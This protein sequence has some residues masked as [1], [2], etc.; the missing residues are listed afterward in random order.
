[1]NE[2]IFGLIL[3]ACWASSMPARGAI[4]ICG[5]SHLLLSAIDGLAPELFYYAALVIEM[6]AVA[7]LFYFSRLLYGW[8]DR[9]FFRGMA[10]FLLLSFGVTTVF[11][12]DRFYYAQT[13]IN[14]HSDYASISLGIAFAHVSF[15]LV[16]SDGIG[17]LF[18]GNLY[19]NVRSLFTGLS[20]RH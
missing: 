18:R 16:C 14:S 6:T 15:M 3:L 1:M 13:I 12:F 7:I 5:F 17:N 19:Y 8:K 10:A 2:I 9:M 11:T 20:H 4:A